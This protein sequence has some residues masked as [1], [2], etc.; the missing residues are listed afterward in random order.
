MSDSQE[1]KRVFISYIRENSDQIDQICQVLQKNNIE[2]WLDRD[3]IDPGKLRR[4]G[5][6]EAIKKGAVFTACFS[7]E[8]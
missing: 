1:T 7:Q 6:R 3:Q 5:I 4:K 2:Y 8:P